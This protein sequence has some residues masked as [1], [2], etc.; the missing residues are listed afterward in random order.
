MSWAP[1]GVAGSRALIARPSTSAFRI[2]L[3][4][5]T[6]DSRACSAGRVDRRYDSDFD[7]V[8]RGL[9]VLNGWA[10]VIGGE[11]TPLTPA[12]VQG[13]LHRG[14]TIL[15]S[16]GTDPYH[17]GGIGAV[18]RTL[19]DLGLEGLVAIGGE[20]T[21]TAAAHLA[22]DGLPLVG[23]PK[24]IDNDLSGTAACI[25]FATAVQVAT[26]AIDRLHT[27]AESHPR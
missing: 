9:G 13:I 18:R 19:I 1:A 12:T 3:R 26:D 7:T 27:T 8:S 14:G 22:E 15:G 5:F 16:S 20:G 24:T 4:T 25:G 11:T 2:H 23:V 6:S 10:G 17:S 21:M